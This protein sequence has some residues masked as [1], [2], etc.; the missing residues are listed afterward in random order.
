MTD[1]PYNASEPSDQREEGASKYLI[2][3]Y[4]NSLIIG[5]GRFLKSSYLSITF[6]VII[7][8][9]VQSLDQ[10]NTLL[11]DMI[12]GDK[13]SLALCFLMIAFFAAVL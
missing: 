11:I 13:L 7:L 3:E 8:L 1:N 12:E 6:I 10:A 2:V 9:L 4:L 5:F